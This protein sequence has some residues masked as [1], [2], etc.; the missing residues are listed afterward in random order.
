MPKSKRRGHGAECRQ[1]ILAGD[2]PFS[3]RISMEDQDA[4]GCFDV[5][6]PARPGCRHGERRSRRAEPRPVVVA[7]QASIPRPA[8]EAGGVAAGADITVAVIPIGGATVTDTATS[9]PFTK[10]QGAPAAAPGLLSSA[11]GAANGRS[12]STADSRSSDP[13][14]PGHRT[15]HS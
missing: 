5:G 12:H 8:I 11:G 7:A 4:L 3:A 6:R 14:G 2:I 15:T 1:A 10:R 9:R 13:A